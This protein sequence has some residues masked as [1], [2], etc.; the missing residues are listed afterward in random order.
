MTLNPS[1]DDDAIWLTDLLAMLPPMTAGTLEGTVAE[2]KVDPALD[3]DEVEKDGAEWWEGYA[4]VHAQE[5]R[6]PEG[7]YY[8]SSLWSFAQ[9]VVDGVAVEEDVRRLAEYCLLFFDVADRPGCWEQLDVVASSYV[10]HPPGTAGRRWAESVM[11]VAWRLYA[12]RQ[13]RRRVGDGL[14]AWP[15]QPG[16]L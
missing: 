14:A 11:E 12:R 4:K 5:G 9:R 16:E 8:R 10:P 13:S 1:I 2:R 6:H 3:S 7:R 15:Q